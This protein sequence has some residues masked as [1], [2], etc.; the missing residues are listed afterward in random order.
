VIEFC[1]Y[2]TPRP[3]G[4]KRAFRRGA[5]VHVVD[6]NPKAADWKL[7]VEQVAGE[8]M[9]GRELLHGPL[10]VSFVFTVTRPKSH[11]GAKGLRP[12]A[13]RFPTTRPDVLKLARS[14]E[15]ACTGLVWRDDA[16]IV[17]E[18][19]RK[20]YGE[21]AGVHVHVWELASEIEEAA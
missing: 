17:L 7:R 18:R 13:P 10:S 14:T 5:H 6:A 16:Q 20:E 8:T 3:G 9:N 2:G 19:L 4:S 12:S 21:Q 15:D 1:V 11:Y